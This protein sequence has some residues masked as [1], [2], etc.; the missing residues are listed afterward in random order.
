M[1]R[2]NVMWNVW[3]H[4]ERAQWFGERT[5][6][7][8]DGWAGQPYTIR[9]A[10]GKA[11]QQEPNYYDLL[12]EKMRY[13]SGHGGSHPFIT[14]EFVQAILEDREPAISVYEAVA[15]T[16]PGI[17]AHESALRGGEQLKVPNFDPA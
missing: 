13:D 14:H 11:I 8:M 16:A 1:F 4:G 5:A 6:M 12:P 15:M 2:C 17:V 7:F 9:T 10:D 3:S